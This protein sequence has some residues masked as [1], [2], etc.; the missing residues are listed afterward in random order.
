MTHLGIFLATELAVSHCG[1]ESV[2]ECPA[3]NKQEEK[4]VV[5][6]QFRGVLSTY[7]RHYIAGRPSSGD[8]AHTVHSKRTVLTW[9]DTPAELL[10]PGADVGS[11]CPR[12]TVSC[13]SRPPCLPAMLGLE[14]VPNRRPAPTFAP[15]I[16]LPARGT[17]CDVFSALVPPFLPVHEDWKPP[18]SQGAPSDDVDCST[19]Q[20][21]HL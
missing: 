3:S 5:H 13:P 19:A 16:R 4:I 15:A 20:E 21:D 11:C 1:G 17:S 9:E 7:G 8:S 18:C 10:C 6:K 2:A 14:T 12:K